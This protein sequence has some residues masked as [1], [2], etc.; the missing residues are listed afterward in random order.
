[1]TLSAGTRLGPYEV[2]EPLGAGG[3]GEVY[4][5]KDTRLDRFVAIKV[6]PAH[7]AANADLRQ[8]LEREAK[9]I[10]GLNHPNICTLHDVGHQDGI[11]YLVMELLDG[12]SLQERLK[13][14]PLPLG[15]AL[16]HAIEIADAL[17]KAHRQGVIHRDLKPANVMLTKSGAKLLDFGL[18][19]QAGPGAGVGVSTL[20]TAEK[21]LTEAGT[22]LGTFQYMAPEQLEGREADARTDVFAF[23]AVLYEMVTGRK[24]FLGKSQASLISAIMQSEPAPI[25]ALAPMVPP[26]LERVVRACLAK[27]ADDRWQSAHDVAAELR[28]IAEAGSGAGS[29]APAVSRRKNRERLAWAIAAASLGV[30]TWL[31]LSRAR[32]APAPSARVLRTTILLPERVQLNNAVLSPDGSRLVF[33]GIDATGKVQLW[34]RPLDTDG[35]TPIAGTEGGVLPFWS[36]DS[37]NVGFFADKKLK[38]VEVTGGAPMTL[39]DVDGV[40][41]AWAPTGDILFTPPAGP[42]SRVPAAGGKPTVATRI[43]TSRGETAHR[44]PF[45][46]PDG[47]HFLYLALNVSGNSRDPANRILVGS[48]DGSP[49]KPV[50]AANY[51][52]QYAD[53]YLLFIRGGDLGGSLL[54]QRFDPVRLET[55]G[56]PVTVVDQIGL[57]PDFLG[58]GDYSVSASGSLVFDAFRLVTRLEWLDRSGR[59]TGVFGEPGPHFN[60]RISPDGMRVAYDLYD[61]GTQTT[62]IWVG[63]VAR[64]VQSRLTTGSSN[65]QPVWS[66]DGSRIAFQSD[67]KHQADVYVRLASGMGSDEAITDENSQKIPNDWSKDGR[68]LALFDREPGG[69]RLIRL[70]AIPVSGDRKPFVVIPPVPNFLGGL[71]FSPDGHWLAYN[72]DESGRNEVYVT[73]FPDGQKRVQISNAGG[74]EPKWTRGGREI[75][76][77]AFDGKV[78]SAEVDLGPRPRVGVPRPLFQLPEGTATGWDVSG[79]GERFLLNVPVIKSSAMP[80]S[81]VT[82]WTAG[83]KK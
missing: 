45:V 16:R 35:A 17:D 4:R 2:A 20:A 81:L 33:S 47:R 14:G 71:R 68:F 11:D 44:Y 38:R 6:L 31:G 73:S 56:D 57:Y 25:S 49:S 46:L 83:L 18:A 70:S 1:M 52:A 19:K 76:Y 21:P 36:P 22:L 26:A 37:R 43:D 75:V 58:F 59:Q 32:P 80:L 10:S 65:S 79:D 34:V 3:M 74:V 69:N 7:V 67:R 77:A 9:T 27:E 28:W 41:G 13:K 55:T 64:G 24:A 62:Q 5:A 29:P 40:G 61:T 50:I 15:P 8:R 53:G 63:D 78:V 12:E 66:P 82:N 23:G 42:I 39:C 30:A 60:P 72:S 51:N 48:L 54:A